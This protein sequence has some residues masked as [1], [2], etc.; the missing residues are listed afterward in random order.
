MTRAERKLDHIKH[1]LS[2][3]QSRATWLDDIRFVH[4]ALPNSSWDSVSLQTQI[5]E[6]VFGSPIFINAM[7]GG[8]G[9]KTTEL[10]SQLA[11]I[12]REMNIPMAVGSQMAAIKN[13][14]EIQSYATVRKE[15][16]NGMIIANLGSEATVDQAKRAVDML[17]AN[18]IQIHLNVIQELTMPEGD[19]DFQGALSRIEQLVNELTV[20][21]IVKETGFGI[22]R[23]AAIKLME[24]NVAAID[25]GGFG[26]TNFAAIEN[27][28]RQRKL[29][30]FNDWGIPTAA[31]LIET[32]TIN[33]TIPLI[34]SGGIQ[35]ALDIVKCLSIGASAV[36]LAGVILK[37]LVD[38]GELATIE[39]I[40][41]INEDLTMLMVSLGANSIQELQQSPL[42]ISGDLHHY[43]SQRGIDTHTYANRK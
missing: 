9:A 30:Y 7:T 34:A 15:N 25:V 23:E 28:R 11:R 43:L 24:M 12:S 32:T 36:G 35:H 38:D 18:A 21:V 4:Q 6:L 40:K 13:S 19:R 10:N 5:G 26:G 41:Q 22:S 27:E 33:S 37:T 39:E 16:P 3:G 29:T 8:G 1:A 20:P 31:S 42:I 17:E 2:T 14:E